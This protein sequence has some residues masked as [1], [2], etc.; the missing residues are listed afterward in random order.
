MNENVVN[1]NVYSTL[2]MKIFTQLGIQ[3][4]AQA[5]NRAGRRWVTTS[6]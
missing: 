5:L 3:N 4:I 1:E 2:P 6:F